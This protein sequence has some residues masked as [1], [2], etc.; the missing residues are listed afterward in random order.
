MTNN[1]K[2]I[3]KTCVKSKFGMHARPASKIAE[4][5]NT[6]KSKIWLKTTSF[7]INAGSIIDILSL[8]AKKSTQVTIEIEDE[9]DI[10]ILENIFNF[11]ENGFEEI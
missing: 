10:I 8:G 3:K 1:K 5:A 9:K 6:A 7:K 2:F 11:F 4:I